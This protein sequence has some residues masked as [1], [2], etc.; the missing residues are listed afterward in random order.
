MQQRRLA[1][2]VRA[3]DDVQ[4]LAHPLELQSAPDAVAFD[5]QGKQFHRRWWQMSCRVTAWVLRGQPPTWHPRR[6][7]SASR[8]HPT[9][10]P[11][12]S[13]TAN[14]AASCRTRFRVAGS[15]MRHRLR[16]QPRRLSFGQQRFHLQG[17]LG[18]EFELPQRAEEVAEDRLLFV[19][20]RRQGVLRFELDAHRPDDG[21]RQAMFDP[22]PFQQI[23][24]EFAA[25]QFGHQRPAAANRPGDQQIA[26]RSLR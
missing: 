3:V 25:T 14:K 26:L 17:L 8:R 12:Q 7:N 9:S 11:A 18:I 15:A 1:R 5:F 10:C 19:E 2:L 6:A 16:K 21:R 24:A 13:S 4:T 20:R 22:Q 23:A